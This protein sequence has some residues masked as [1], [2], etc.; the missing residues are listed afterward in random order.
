MVPALDVAKL[1]GE[2]GALEAVHAGVPA[3]LVVVVAASHAVLAQHP[4]AL[5][6]VIGIHSDHAGVAGGAQVLGGIKAEGG[7]VAQSAGLDSAPFRAPG[8]GCVFNDSQAALLSKTR[9]RI[10]ALA[11]EVDGEDGADEFALRAIEH[12]FDRRG[13]EVEGGRVNVGQQG[14]GAG[15][16]NCADRGKEAE[17]RGDHSLAGANS[18]GGQRQPE[19][20]SPRTASNCMGH[21]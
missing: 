6:Q 18:G 8:L 13:R 16:K 20:I 2:N 5:G 4:G 14:C 12:T 10:G 3:D 19:G 15:A 21:S 9:K 11:K 7:D 1:D 17:R